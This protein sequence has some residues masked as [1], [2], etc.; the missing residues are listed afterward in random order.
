MSNDF[1]KGYSFLMKTNYNNNIDEL[2]DRQLKSYELDELKGDFASQLLESKKIL[3]SGYRLRKIARRK[4]KLPKNVLEKLIKII[5]DSKTATNDKNLSY[6]IQTL[7]YSLL[8]ENNYDENEY[9]ELIESMF[10]LIENEN[11]HPLN[12]RIQI[13]QCLHFVVLKRSTP[14]KKFKEKLNALLPAYAN[15]IDVSQFYFRLKKNQS[16]FHKNTSNY[17]KWILS[18]KSVTLNRPTFVTKTLFK[19]NHR[20]SNFLSE[21]FLALGSNDTDLFKYKRKHN[22]KEAI[23]TKTFAESQSDENKSDWSGWSYFITN[24]EKLYG[25]VKNDRV[26]I[27]KK[28]LD[29][30]LENLASLTSLG[31]RIVRKLWFSDKTSEYLDNILPF[32]VLETLLETVRLDNS[33][34]RTALKS[35]QVEKLLKELHKIFDFKFKYIDKTKDRQNMINYFS[36]YGDV[37]NKSYPAIT[38]KAFKDLGTTTQD[39]LGGLLE[40]YLNEWRSCVFEIASLLCRT[41]HRDKILQDRK[42]KDNGIE[43]MTSGIPALKKRA[44]EFFREFNDN[45]NR[46]AN[47][48]FFEITLNALLNDNELYQAKEILQLI[49]SDSNKDYLELCKSNLVQIGELVVNAGSE[50][51]ADIFYSCIS[52]YNLKLFDGYNSLAS[53]MNNCLASALKLKNEN[54][55]S[56][57]LDILLHHVQGENNDDKQI[58][59]CVCKALCELLQE[60]DE[61]NEHSIR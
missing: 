60:I 61:Q 5:K 30:M 14:K 1:Y 23:V 40:K 16:D 42:L 20:N 51:I 36:K 45:S 9:D 52:K 10:K 2:L 12:I 55:I 26:S 17:P 44:I 39:C 8:N 6:L 46:K 15:Q 31:P 32:M 33:Y 19:A 49:D 43:F 11:L 29:F 41:V 38:K 35:E 50:E 4:I 53:A 18:D 54:V 3:Y 13:L 37:S 24:I 27:K 57:I 47:K 59:E 7:K 34:R 28:D 58:R 48:S 22:V 25:M 21:E 56:I